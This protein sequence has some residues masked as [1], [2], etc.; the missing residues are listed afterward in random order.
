MSCPLVLSN[1][2]INKLL[3]TL[4]NQG[5]WTAPTTVYLALYTTN[6]NPNNSGTE[7]STSG[8]S[9]Y[10]RQAISWAS[11]GS[12]LSVANNAVITF[13]TASTNWGAITYL[14]LFDAVSGGNMLM[15]TPLASSILINSGSIFQTAIGNLTAAFQ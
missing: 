10:V 12:N 4:T 6:P 1:Y 11:V 7:V 15:F 8:G 3:L 14:A 2:L 5:Q 13:P 9:G